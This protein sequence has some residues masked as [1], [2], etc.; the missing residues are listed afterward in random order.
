[1][2]PRSSCPIRKGNRQPA[3][4]VF[5]QGNK[6]LGPVPGKIYSLGSEGV[7][8]IFM[9][10]MEKRVDVVFSCV[11][12]VPAFSSKILLYPFI[13]LQNYKELS[14]VENISEKIR[15]CCFAT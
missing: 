12:K 9:A 11:K 5:N 2:F 8:M 3:R 10:S 7:N 14:R 15:Y 13:G 4:P 6:A 1:M